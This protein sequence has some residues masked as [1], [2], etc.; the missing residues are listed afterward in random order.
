MPMPPMPSPARCHRWWTC[1]RMRL[2]CGHCAGGRD[3]H[4]IAHTRKTPCRPA[5][6]TVAKRGGPPPIAEVRLSWVSTCFISSVVPHNHNISKLL[7]FWVEFFILF[8]FLNFFFISCFVNLQFILYIIF[9]LFFL[10]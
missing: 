4:L 9:L 2:T 5:A 8:N 1:C 6:A 3:T 10:F 7:F